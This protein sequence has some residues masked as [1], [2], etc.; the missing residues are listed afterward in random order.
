LFTVF[1]FSASGLIL[2]AGA[3]AALYYYVIKKDTG[4]IADMPL[5]VE[6]QNVEKPQT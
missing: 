2:I 6:P 1:S 5:K 3:S 4:D